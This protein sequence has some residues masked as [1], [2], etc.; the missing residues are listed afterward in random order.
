M[1]HD[2]NVRNDFF[3]DDRKV[4]LQNKNGETLSLRGIGDMVA[5]RTFS[6]ERVKLK[7]QLCVFQLNCNLLSVVKIINHGYN[8][9]FGKRGA[10]V[11]AGRN[12]VKMS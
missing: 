12:N 2:E 7:N 5:K 10:I 4:Y 6:D 8:V 3:K 11:C 1:I 9:N